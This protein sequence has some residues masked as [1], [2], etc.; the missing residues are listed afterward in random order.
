MPR[1]LCRSLTTREAG[2]KATLRTGRRGNAQAGVQ[3]AGDYRQNPVRRRIIDAPVARAY[4]SNL[5]VSAIE[6]DFLLR[7]ALGH[8][9]S[10]R[11]SR[12]E[13]VGF[14]RKAESQP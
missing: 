7:L 3:T 4:N 1:A 13:T 14:E 11:L 10:L 8:S 5:G 6:S 9:T 12:L 2:G